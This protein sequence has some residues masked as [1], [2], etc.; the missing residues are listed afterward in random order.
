MS[1]ATHGASS[2]CYYYEAVIIGGG[3]EEEKRGVKRLLQ[4]SEENTDSD[5]KQK[6]N[7]TMNGHI[8][9]GWSTRHADLQAPV[10]YNEHS[11]AIRDIMGSR[12]HGSRREDTW[13]GVSFGPG[14]VLGLAICLV[15]KQ[16][17]TS[18]TTTTSSGNAT[19]TVNDTENKSESNQEKS[20][21]VTNHIRFFKNGQPLG[22]DNGIAFDNINPGT[23]HPAVSCY[24][25]GAVQ[26]NFGPHFV[27]PP[28][29]ELISEI[30]LRPISDLCTSPPSPDVA[31]EK[32]ITAG[33]GKKASLLAKRADDNIVSAFKELVKTE[34]KA[35]H[36]AYNKHLD[37]H[38]KEIL[39]WRKER[40]LPT[41]L[42]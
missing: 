38:K 24:M 19:T 21:C 17:G 9:I 37:L 29:Q 16:Q 28:P 13:G 25:N 14:D 5:K 35:R 30:N 40:G 34:V 1:R 42:D 15:D 23:Y 7:G 6:T 36:D 41:T 26:M 11:F 39:G 20:S 12:I 2:G 32:V 33:E 3:D 31:V 18:E 10:G 8:R 4:Q 27:Y 22:K